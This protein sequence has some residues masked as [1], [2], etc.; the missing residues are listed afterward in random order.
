MA[1]KKQNKKWEQENQKL[2]KE[3]QEI[4]D[5][6]EIKEEDILPVDKNG[7]IQFDFNNPRHVKIYERWME[8]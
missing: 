5:K 6:I 3:I 1:R 7:V 2:L 8:D 4:V